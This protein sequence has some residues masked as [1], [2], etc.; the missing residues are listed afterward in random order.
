MLGVFASPA[1]SIQSPNVI[2]VSRI[3]TGNVLGTRAMR[4]GLFG[5]FQAELKV[6]LHSAIERSIPGLIMSSSKPCM[7]SASGTSRKQ[8]EVNFITDADNQAEWQ[9]EIWASDSDCINREVCLKLFCSPQDLTEDTVKAALDSVSFEIID[10]LV[11]SVIQQSDHDELEDSYLKLAEI[12]SRNFSHQDS[13]NH[14]GSDTS[15][16]PPSSPNPTKIVRALGLNNPSPKTLSNLE[17]ML[18]KSSPELLPKTIHIPH[19]SSII[20]TYPSA[21]MVYANDFIPKDLWIPL[22]TPINNVQT[23]WI[24]KWS[25]MDLNRSVVSGRGY[26]VDFSDAFNAE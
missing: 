6:A 12:V 15:S 21:S 10:L 17:S 24:L 19:L 11:F 14:D 2:Q 4:A 3:H 25:V 18:R 7:D 1:S 9:S 20:E 13:I 8:N 16:L 23:R 22:A 26:V 5:G